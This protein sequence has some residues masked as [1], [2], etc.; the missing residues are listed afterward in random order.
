MVLSLLLLPALRVAYAEGSI[1]PPE[2]LPLGGYTERGFKRMVGVGDDLELRVWI[3]RPR[4][5]APIALA[6]METLTIPESLRKE[7]QDQ[8]PSDYRLILCATHTHCAPDSQMFNDRMTFAIPGVAKYDP[9]WLGWTGLRA[10]E[11]FRQAIRAQ[12]LPVP[13]LGVRRARLNL[14]RGRRPGA[15]PD[16]LGTR[17]DFGPRVGFWHYAAHATFYD[18]SEMRTRGDWPGAVMATTKAPVLLGP[19][20]D[21]SPQSPGDTA[22]EKIASFTREFRSR[23]AGRPS[24]VWRPED[25]I[26]FVEV[27]IKLPKR[28]PHPAFAKTYKIPETMA[29][30]LVERFAPESA[31]VGVLRMGSMA[32]VAVPGE[33]TAELGRQ[34]QAYGERRG[35]RP[36]LVLSHANGWIGY[37]LAPNDYDRGGYEANLS[38]YG[39][40]GGAA[41]VTTAYRAIDTVSKAN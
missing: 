31:K 25:P 41:V 37:L 39:R 8:L 16:P 33:P 38:F 15:K 10:G 2:K 17:V 14:N 40:D 3:L 4:G 26:N 18:S 32:V 20:G 27:A 9:Y 30:N 7:L 21:V 1:T 19:I 24:R 22:P 36:T 11:I 5:Q 29:Q 35:F 6:V 28:R 13:Y 34:I 23:L 12:D